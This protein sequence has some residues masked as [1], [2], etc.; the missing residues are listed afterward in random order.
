MLMLE[1]V[2]MST[3]NDVRKEQNLNENEYVQT[4]KK[5]GSTTLNPKQ[6][7]KWIDTDVHG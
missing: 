2:G 6:T 4:S 1:S 7:D 3:A 5:L